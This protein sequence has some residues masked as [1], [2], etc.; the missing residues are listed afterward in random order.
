MMRYIL[1]LLILLFTASLSANAQSSL[2]WTGPSKIGKTK[3]LGWLATDRG[4]FITCQ[5][6]LKYESGRDIRF[7]IGSK[8]SPAILLRDKYIRRMLSG[9]VGWQANK[10]H[11]AA[12]FVDKKLPINLSARITSSTVILIP[13]PKNQPLLL[14]TIYKGK[15]ISISIG[16]VAMKNYNVTG[17]AQATSWIQNCYK[18][19]GSSKKNEPKIIVSSDAFPIVPALEFDTCHRKQFHSR[20]EKLTKQLIKYNTLI[21]YFRGLTFYL[22]SFNPCKR[23]KKT[24][25]VDPVATKDLVSVS[26]YLGSS[27]HFLSIRSIDPLPGQR[28]TAIYGACEGQCVHFEGLAEVRFHWEETTGVYRLVPLKK[29]SDYIYHRY[30]K[31]LKKVRK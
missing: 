30:E 29:T 10:N 4:S 3:W 9:S 22:D 15:S 7:V 27:Q 6:S 25:I 2:T 12:I 13:L 16:G 18:S 17:L 1:S 21:V 5:A 8:G 31:T 19:R 14:D 24:S 26:D 11:N 23:S 28:K 20:M